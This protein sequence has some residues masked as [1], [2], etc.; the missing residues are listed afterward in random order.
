M[1]AAAI[2]TP[3]SPRLF[4]GQPYPSRPVRLVVGF[5]AGGPVDIAARIIAPW[6][7]ERLGQPFVVDNRPGESGNRATRSVVRAA[8]DGCTLLVCGPVNTINTNLFQGLDY[9]FTRDIAPVASL[10]RVPLVIEVHP[11]VA[12]KTLPEFIAYAK[13]NPGKLKIGFAGKGTPQHVAIELFKMMT[14]ADFTLVSYLGS[15]PALADLLVGKI[16]AMFDPMPSS[17][18]HI[19]R[20]KLIPLAVTTPSRSEALPDVPAASELV[21]GYE[22][23]SWFGIGAPKRTAADIIEKLNSEVNAGLESPRIKARLAEL[24][25]SA[26]RGSQAQFGSFIVRETDKYAGVI[27]TAKIKLE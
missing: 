3:L 1:A 9:N 22:A 12:A 11:S 5:P 26:I 21:T 2:V 10:W 24:G 13:A 18:S 27:R 16:D 7:A 20:G 25:A 6:L 19:R 15:T 4:A 8:P 23:A 17:I 14:G